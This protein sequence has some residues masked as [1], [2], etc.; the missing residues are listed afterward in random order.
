MAASSIDI[1][2]ILVYAPKMAKYS[3]NF[4]RDYAF[5]LAHLGRFGFTGGALI[6]EVPY[7]EDGV[8]AKRAFFLY[9]SNGKLVPCKEPDLFK[10][11]MITKKGINFH[12]KLWAEGYSDML[13]G[14]HEYIEDF[15][16]PPD[17]VEE[18]FRKLLYKE[19]TKSKTYLDWKEE[20]TTLDKS[21]HP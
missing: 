1:P 20:R 4:E 12:L 9:D 7:A 2:P 3:K 8:D 15:T 13:M 10:S 16:D 17:W 21:P 18:S 6:P 5:Y 14:V 19:F 11:L